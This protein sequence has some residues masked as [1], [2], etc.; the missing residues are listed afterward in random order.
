MFSRMDYLKVKWFEPAYSAELSGVIPSNWIETVLGV[1]VVRWPNKIDSL[2]HIMERTT[3]KAD[4]KI[5]IYLKTMSN[6]CLCSQRQ[7]A[8]MLITVVL[9][10]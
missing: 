1:K 10:W 4:W 8:F 6:T 5:F 7:V 3:P 2:A 9:L